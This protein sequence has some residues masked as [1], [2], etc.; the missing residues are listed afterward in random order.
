[1]A[2]FRPLFADVQNR[3]GGDIAA[4]LLALPGEVACSVGYPAGGIADRQV[5]LSGEVHVQHPLHTS[6]FAL[7]GEQATLLVH[8]L[9]T[10]TS[11][12]MTEPRDEAIDLAGVIEDVLAEDRTLGGLVDSVFV[13]A[14]DGEEGIPEE[15][16]RQYGLTLQIAY[17]GT[18]VFT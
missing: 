3:L 5:W 10:M 18:A 7:R 2:G 4:A 6:G 14:A 9:V 15:R 16:T 11:D 1:M 12:T 8:I 13:A 17:D